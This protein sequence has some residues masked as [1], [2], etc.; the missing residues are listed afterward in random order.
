[1]TN[2][3][4]Q[5]I[6]TTIRGSNRQVADIKSNPGRLQIGIGGRLP[7]GMRGRLVGIRT[8]GKKSLAYPPI[9]AL[10]SV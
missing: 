3:A 4:K 2:P 9:S 5:N 6:I 1:L 8:G 10:P 7:I